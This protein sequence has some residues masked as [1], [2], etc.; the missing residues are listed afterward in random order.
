M[1][2]ICLSQMVFLLMLAGA[3]SNAFGVEIDAWSRRE[4][5]LKRTNT[6][7]RR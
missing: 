4:R 3:V 5:A 6:N 7:I 2:S 1:K